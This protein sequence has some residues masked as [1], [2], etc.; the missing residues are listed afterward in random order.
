M[1]KAKDAEIFQKNALVLPLK[2][3]QNLLYSKQIPNVKILKYDP[4]LSLYLVKDK[5][6]FAY[7]YDINMR[8]QLGTA[9]LNAKKAK[10]GK[11]LQT[12]IGL[13][14]FAKYNQTLASPALI[15]SSCCSV[16]GIATSKGVIQ[17]EYIKHFL[18]TKSTLYGDIG[19]RVYNKNAQVLVNASDPFMKEN[20][21]KINDCIIEYDHKKV[22]NAA[23]LMQKILFSSV[24]SKH[25]VKIKRGSRFLTFVLTCK[26]RYGGGFVSDTF[27]EQKGIYFDESLHVKHLNKE[28]Q[29]YGLNIGDRLIQ[30]NGVRIKNQ[31]ELRRYIENFKDYSSLLFERNKFQFFVNI[32]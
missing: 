28:F 25:Q 7:P 20:P 15:S 9:I 5:K 8:L 18:H 27:L 16:E 2:N 24:G 11:F 22:G 19:I 30:V 10:E 4:F 29:K 21:F 32:K 26:Q 14:T 13:N 1:Q 23:S 12:Q 3:A 6:P 31:N 17:K